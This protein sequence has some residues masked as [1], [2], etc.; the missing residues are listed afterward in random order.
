MGKILFRSGIFAPESRGP[1][2]TLRYSADH[3]R[4]ERVC[5][6]R[7]HIERIKLP[8]LRARQ[9]RLAD[10]DLGAAARHRLVDLGADGLGRLAWHHR[11]RG[12]CTRNA[13]WPARWGTRG[14]RQPTWPATPRPIAADAA[15]AYAL[16]LDRNRHY[17]S[18]VTA[19][20]GPARRGG[21]RHQPA[22]QAGPGTQPGLAAELIDGYRHQLGCLQLGALSRACHRRSADRGRRDGDRLRCQCSKLPRLSHGSTRLAGG[23]S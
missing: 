20:C 2:H 8:P 21:D 9:R 17:R 15:G 13:G 23:P 4:N 11:L 14:P 22:G 6:N 5:G 1:R 10:R 19:G 12:S 16:R 3:D 18:L 7:R